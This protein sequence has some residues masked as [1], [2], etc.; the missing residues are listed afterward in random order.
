VLRAIY[1]AGGAAGLNS[2][3]LEKVG[4][5]AR[6]HSCPGLLFAAGVSAPTVSAVL[7][8]ADTRTTLTTYA[9]LVETNRTELRRDL[10]MAFA[11]GNQ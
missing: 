6:R 11:D 10:D 8:H 4:C 7:R 9:G 3:E 1:R 5:H 2:D